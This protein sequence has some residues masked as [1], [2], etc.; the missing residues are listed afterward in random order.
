[1]ART[2][3]WDSATSQFSINV[4]A[5]AFLDEQYAVFGSVVSG[6]DVVDKMA[7]VQTGAAGRFQ[8]DVPVETMS[9]I[10]ISRK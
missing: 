9:I 7:T 5:N 8:S 3:V 1:M 4:A 10:S 6:M 2:Q